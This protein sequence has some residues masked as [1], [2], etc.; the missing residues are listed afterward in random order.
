MWT[1]T[2]KDGG[3]SSLPGFQ[4][5]KRYVESR[6]LSLVTGDHKKETRY[7]EFIGVI[8]LSTD[9]IMSKRLVKRVAVL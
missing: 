7:V 9:R 2:S 1:K 6:A 4:T 5:L 8:I 3:A